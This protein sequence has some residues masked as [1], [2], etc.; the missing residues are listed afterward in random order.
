M[1]DMD[2]AVPTHLTRSKRELLATLTSIPYFEGLSQ[3]ELLFLVQQGYPQSLPQL[4]YVCREG[5]V[6]NSFYVILSGKVEVISLRKK[7]HIS[8]LYP[9]D[10]FGE[11]AL[12]TGSPR[13]ATCRTLEDSRFFVIHRDPLRTILSA[14]RDIAEKIALK[15][16]DRQDSLISLGVLNFD[17]T[18]EQEALLNQ[19]RKRLQH[20]FKP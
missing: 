15:L 16:L 12:F 9:G 13:L 10:F 4:Q 5:D 14:H 11:I 7:K 19:I 18:S 6:A 1:A 20:L 17:E 2:S 8:V 3:P